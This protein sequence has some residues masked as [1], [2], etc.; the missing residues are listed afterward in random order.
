M[1]PNAR[2]SGRR[3]SQK[4]AN[5]PFLAYQRFKQ[6]E[7]EKEERIK[8]GRPLPSDLPAPWTI[9]SFIKPLIL[10]LLFTPVFG[11]FLTGSPAF[12]YEPQIRKAWRAYGPKKSFQEFTP[13]Q[14]AA[15]DGSD[16]KKP[17]YLAIDG[18]VYDVSSSA[19]I[20]GPEGSYHMMYVDCCS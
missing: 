16:P 3:V 2:Q 14:L 19:R 5:K 7:S 15:F 12:G 1:F 13:V 10:L 6:L 4:P 9:W 20:Y 11:Q 17:I 8:A 18:D